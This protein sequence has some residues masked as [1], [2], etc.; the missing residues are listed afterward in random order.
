MVNVCVLGTGFVGLT[1]SV[2]LAEKG[3]IVYGVDLNK[4]VINKLNTGQPHFHEPGLLEALTKN[5]K[6][7]FFFLEIPDKKIDVFI[8]CVGTPLNKD[9]SVNNR[10]LTS[11]SESIS[12]NMKGNELIVLRSTVTVGATRN[13]VKPILDKSGKKYFLTFCPER[14]VEGKAVYEQSALPQIIGGINLESTKKAAEFFKTIVEEVIITE[15]AEEAEIVKLLNNS[16]RNLTFAFANEIALLC[17]TLGINANHAID[18]A[19]HNY[20]RSNIP[21][22][23]FVGGPC[24][25]KDSFII[26]ASSK[27]YPLINMLVTTAR[28]V[29]DFMPEFIAEKVSRHTNKKSNI[30]VCG[31]AFKGKP[32]TDDIRNSPSIELI[33][34]LK[35]K[36]H[37]KIFGQDFAVKNQIILETGI[38]SMEFEMGILEADCVIIANNHEKYKKINIENALNKKR[39]PTV[40]FDIWH[41]LDAEKIDKTKVTYFTL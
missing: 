33:N 37:E 30:L 31:L 28:E 13:I 24:L 16:Y 18:A 7:I 5:R 23:G 12:K 4:T 20:K 40:V 26:K 29:N 22:P 11:A 38:T 36:G 14:A 2:V 19:N 41:M 15:S 9:N 27:N 32:E 6:N 35:S 25:T 21:K 1:L 39:T 17:N 3:H 34:L 10:F 8:V